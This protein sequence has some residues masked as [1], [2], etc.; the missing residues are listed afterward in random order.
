MKVEIKEKEEWFKIAN[1]LG[2]A[3]VNCHPDF[4]EIISNVFEVIPYCA[5]I[6]A[7]EIPILG[8]L[9]YSKKKSIVHPSTYFYTAVWSNS[10]STLKL[11]EAFITYISSLKQ[12]FKFM[13]FLL[14]PHVTDVRPFI[15]TG[16]KPYVNYTYVN[17]LI[18]TKINSDE[19]ILKN[20]SDRIG[21]IYKWEDDNIDV[22]QQHLRSFSQLGYSRS[23]VRKMEL[24]CSKLL[25]KNFL[26]ALSARLN[27]NLLASSFT[28]IDN[29]QKK[30]YNLLVTSLKT[31]YSTRVHSGL[32]IK[33]FEYLRS[34]GIREIDLFGAT[35][36]GIGNF[37]SNFGSE[38]KP[39]YYVKYNFLRWQ[40]V[41]IWNFLKLPLFKILNK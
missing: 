29:Y 28:L 38:L 33:I 30:S 19:K 24:L 23:F 18:E 36:K 10:N 26:K 16:F 17:N 34:L 2:K 25:E 13:E 5:I 27:D 22:L 9:A 21:V 32:Y 1:E 20:K 41:K 35:T 15:Y 12:K 3:T 37:K 4:V 11:Q 8:I 31:H 6:Y 7:N 39:F 14:P 40:I